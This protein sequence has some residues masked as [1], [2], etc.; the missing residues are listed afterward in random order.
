ME[1]ENELTLKGIRLLSRLTNSITSEDMDDKPLIVRE[2]S[3]EMRICKA[4]NK[5]GEYKPLFNEFHKNGDGDKY[6]AYSQCRQCYSEKRREQHRI[7]NRTKRK[8][9]S[10]QAALNYEKVN[11][12]LNRENNREMNVNAQ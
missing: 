9:R 5:C 11:A 8:G 3:G 7:Y 12:K 6:G 2:V 10:K 4:C 1:M